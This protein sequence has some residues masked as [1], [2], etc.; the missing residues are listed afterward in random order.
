M[1]RQPRLDASG[2]AHHVM[3]RG[4]ER[5]ALFAEAPDRADFGAC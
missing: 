2:T 4:V 5:R 1:P 3:V